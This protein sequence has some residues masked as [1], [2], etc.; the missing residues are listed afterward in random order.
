MTIRPQTQAVLSEVYNERLRQVLRFGEQVIPDIAPGDDGTPLFPETYARYADQIRRENDTRPPEDQFMI[1]V[2]LEEVFE[3]CEA[4]AA[5]DL[6]AYRAEMIQVA[7]L[8]VKAIEL[9]DMRMSMDPGL[10]GYYEQHGEDR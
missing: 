10:P 5:G 7:A 4:R 6:S 8:A 9:V 3:A 2:L 1:P